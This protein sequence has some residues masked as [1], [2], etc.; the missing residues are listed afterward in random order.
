MCHIYIYILLVLHQNPLNINFS[1]SFQSFLNCRGSFHR[2]CPAPNPYMSGSRVLAYIYKGVE[3]PSNP[4][5]AKPLSSLSCGGQGSPKVIWDTLHRI[6]SISRG[7]NS[8]SPQDLQ[9]LSG[10]LSPKV[11]SRFSF[12]FF[13]LLLIFLSILDIFTFEHL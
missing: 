1:G 4:N 6:P 7:F 9:T 12:N 10:S 11:L 13:D 2:T 8:P 3:Y 5:L